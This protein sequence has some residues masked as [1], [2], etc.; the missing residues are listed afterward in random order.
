MQPS[1][2]EIGIIL[3]PDDIKVANVMRAALKDMY[4]GNKPVE[5]RNPNFMPPLQ[6]NESGN[7]ELYESDVC[8]IVRQANLATGDARHFYIKRNQEFSDLMDEG[9][10]DTDRYK[11]L[12]KE[13]PLLAD[14]IGLFGSLA[15]AAVC[16]LEVSQLEFIFRLPAVQPPSQLV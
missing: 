9:L 7:L 3:E 2:K 4:E 15:T 5:D 10:F 12:E 1:S 14:K 6:P 16:H 13:L 11:E 8:H